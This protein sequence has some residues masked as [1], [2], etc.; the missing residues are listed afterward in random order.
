MEVAFGVFKTLTVA[1]ILLQST[2]GVNKF[3]EN[4]AATSNST[5]H[6]C[7]RNFHTE[8]L[9]AWL[10]FDAFY[11]KQGI[12]TYLLCKEKRNWINYAE[13]TTRHSTDLVARPTRHAGCVRSWFTLLY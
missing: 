7:D 13:N 6:K 11:S 5:R 8:D 9:R 1:Y 3:Y 4:V 12:G 2:P 10:L